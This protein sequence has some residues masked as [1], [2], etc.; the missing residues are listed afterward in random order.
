MKTSPLFYS[1]LALSASLLPSGM[2]DTAQK[3]CR[4]TGGYVQI[5][6]NNAS[7]TYYSGCNAPACGKT[8]AGFTAAMSQLSF[9]APPGLGAGDACG[10][11]FAITGTQDPYSPQYTGSM[12]NT[13][14]V[15][16]TDL[17]PVAGNYE[18]CG[19]TTGNP[20][21]QHKQPVHF[22]LCQDSGAPQAFFPKGRGALTGYY[23]EVSCT[24]WAGSGEG[25]ALWPGACLAPETAPNWPSSAC[26]NQGTAPS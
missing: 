26:G 8:A 2:A 22:D 10:R 13:I 5:A 11:C 25:N 24:L 18:F 3:Q 16:V 1:L 7:F 4:A 19:Q 6:T 12:G 15:R 23:I 20:L 17:C 21:N 14:V 9:G